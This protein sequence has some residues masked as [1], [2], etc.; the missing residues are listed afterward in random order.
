MPRAWRTHNL[1]RA[2]LFLKVNAEKSLQLGGLVL[3]QKMQEFSPVWTARM[4]R[5]VEVG[6]VTYRDAAFRV[7][8]G[9]TVDYAKYTELE[10]W[11]IG[12]RPG[13]ISQLKGAKIP[14]MRPA[15]DAVRHE[16]RAVVLKGFQNTVRLL[17]QG[18]RRRA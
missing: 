18:L 15:A 11:I 5:S 13:P 7:L 16:V 1:N 12:K 4:E 8:V 2:T 14:W 3:K 6:D 10:P 9:P 17:Q